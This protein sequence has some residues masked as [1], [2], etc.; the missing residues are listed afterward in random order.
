V[1]AIWFEIKV[2]ETLPQKNVKKWGK[3]GNKISGKK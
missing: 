2:G 3:N 1:A